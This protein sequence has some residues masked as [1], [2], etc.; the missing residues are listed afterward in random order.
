M[1][2]RSYSSEPFATSCEIVACECGRTLTLEQNLQRDEVADDWDGRGLFLMCDC[3]K[4]G[5]REVDEYAAAVAWN[6]G[7]RVM[8]LPSVAASG[9]PQD[10]HSMSN[11]AAVVL[12]CL[13]GCVLIVFGALVLEVLAA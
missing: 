3:G 12:G 10:G 1:R 13:I 5:P 7:A 11:A 2:L 4:Q 9:L 6:S 8:P